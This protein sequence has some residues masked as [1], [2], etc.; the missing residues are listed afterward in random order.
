MT[1]DPLPFGSEDGPNGI[2]CSCGEWTEETL[3]GHRLPSGRMSRR[4]PMAK[5]WEHYR[6]HYVFANQLT[7]V[8]Q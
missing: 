2:K 3:T 4:R 7:Q 6:E 8:A 5:V 1:H